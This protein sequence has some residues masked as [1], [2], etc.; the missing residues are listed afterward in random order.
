MIQLGIDIGGSKIALAGRRNGQ[1]V[2][3][4]RISINHQS[5][6][7]KVLQTIC[8]YLDVQCESNG[9]IDVIAI[10]TAPNLD[11]EGVVTSWHNFPFW[12]GAKIVSSLVPF[13]KNKILWCDDG[14][15][16]TL[17]DVWA[18]GVEN[19]IHFVLGT[20]VGGGIFYD[21]YILR[22]CEL[23]HLLVYPA[24]VSCSC[25]RKG[26]LQA[27]A[28]AQ[29]FESFKKFDPGTSKDADWEE[30]AA[31]AI[32]ICSANLIEIFHS[33]HITLSGGVA[34]RFPLL[35]DKI[36]KKLLNNFLKK[37]LPMPVIRFSP[38]GADAPL[39]GALALTVA[40]DSVHRCNHW[41]AK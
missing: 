15:A 26:C 30:S 4:N 23:G 28:S 29:S 20:G 35:P 25:G 5:I 8:E 1:I 16:A 33:T 21:G 22:D 11:Q 10:A 9:P 17:A 18:L 39:Q 3:S 36:E 13:A 40:N 2:Y 7:T 37:T 31:E 32:A 27:Y 6:P 38:Y 34:L 19:L 14:T 12:K 24:G 41:L